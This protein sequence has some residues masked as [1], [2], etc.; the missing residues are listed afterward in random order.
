VRRLT[1]EPDVSI[2]VRESS[3]EKELLSVG[4]PSTG[5][6]LRRTKRC[7][8]S[9]DRSGSRSSSR[10]S[11]S[12]KS[13]SPSVASEE[14]YKEWFDKFDNHL[15]AELTLPENDDDEVFD[16]DMEEEL[17]MD[18]DVG[19]LDGTEICNI[20]E[21]RNVSVSI[22]L[23]LKQKLASKPDEN[24]HPCKEFQEPKAFKTKA[25]ELEELQRTWGPKGGRRFSIVPST[26]EQQQCYVSML[27]P[28]EFQ[29]KRE[30]VTRK[31][32]HEHHQHVHNVG[33]S[34][35]MKKI[36]DHHSCHLT[37]S[38]SDS[39]SEVPLDEV[40]MLPLFCDETRKKQNKKRK[41]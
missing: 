9:L 20:D 5:E 15:S 8:N 13:K 4:S 27:H 7:I 38:D 16:S 11:R 32:P 22:T 23:N 26:E 1:P 31:E 33:Y 40:Q 12:R 25:E 3:V 37:L 28:E 35:W 2:E 21:E 10:L 30:E 36:V 24:C 41:K 39:D 19:N 18:A 6:G 29:P 17:L 14:D 34:E